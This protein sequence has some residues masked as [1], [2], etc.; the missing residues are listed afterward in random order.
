MHV[1]GRESDI[2][3][4]GQFITRNPSATPLFIQNSSC[5]KALF[6]IHINFLLNNS[7]NDLLKN[8]ILSL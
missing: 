5:L 7:I 8:A 3:E 6:D 1:R 2:P 4:V